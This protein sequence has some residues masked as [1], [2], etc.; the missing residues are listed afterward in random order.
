MCFVLD[1]DQ[2]HK[3]LWSSLASLLRSYT[4]VR[5]IHNHRHVTIEASEEKITLSFEEKWLSLK[6]DGA[7][8]TWTREN[9][10][11]G[12][13][14][15]SEAGRLRTG[16]SEEEMDMAAETWARELMQ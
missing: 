12:M 9:G 4:A 15:I 2:L 6:R 13:L 16:T 3:E 11:C 1:S 8:V 7:I 10:N 14:E 5:G